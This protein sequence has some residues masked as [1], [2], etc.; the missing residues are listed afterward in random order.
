M[1]DLTDRL[2]ALSPEQRALLEARLRDKGIKAPRSTVIRPIPDRNELAHFPTSL[3]QERLWFIDQ[4]EPGNPAYN[5][6]TATRLFGP[7][8]PDLM[9]RAVNT[10]IARHEI[11][12]TT[13]QV[14]D[15]RPVQVVAPTLEIDLP[16]IDLTHVPP[17]ERE[18]A[19]QNAAVDAAS[20]RF[21]LER[22]PL[23]R[24]VLAR[25]AP[26]DHVLMICMQHA[27]TDRWSFDIFEAEVS[28]CYVAL[29][30]GGSVERPPLALQFADFAAWQREELSGENLDRH[31][32]YWRDK[33]A[34]AP[35]VL[36]IPADRPRPPVQTFNGAREYTVYPESVLEAL[37]EVTRRAGATMFMTVLAALDVLCWRY[38]GQR[39]LIIGSAI[40]DRNRPETADVIGY[41][42]NMLLLRGTIDPS[43]S[44][45]QLLAQVRETALGAYAHQD[46]PFAT[47]VSELN[48]RQDPSR[49][50]L[51]QISFIY[52]DFPVLATPE[53]A[54]FSATSLD[55]DNG[56]SRF[57]MTLACTE[58]PGTGIH[59]YIEY[60][61]DIYGKPK[62]ERMLRHLG[63]IL[64]AVAAEPDRP[65]G[66]IDILSGEERR[67]LVT[68]F[69]DTAKAYGDECLHDL[70]SRAAAGRPAEPAILFDGEA[71]SYGRLEEGASRIAGKLVACG[72]GRGSLV[73]VCVERSPEQA[74]A[75][76]G[77]L[78][79][80]AAY[81]PLDPSLP[82]GRIRRILDQTRPDLVLV[83]R[84]L[85]PVLP[86][87]GA[88]VLQV[89]DALEEQA[90]G[91]GDGL[92]SG[93]S[94]GDLAYVMFT[95][96]STGIPKGVMISHRAILNR[97]HWSQERYP[98][99]PGDRV[100]HSA[101]FGFD[102]AAWELFGPLIAGATA[103]IPRE[104][105]HKDAGALA[106]L[107]AEHGVRVAHFVP[108]MLRAF[109]EDPGVESCTALQTILC[110]GEAMDRD[111]HDRLFQ[112]FPGSTLAHFYGPTEAAISCLAHDCEPGAAGG[113]VPL[114]RPVS[115]MRIYLLDDSLQ[116]V[117]AGVPGQITIGGAGLARGYLG[118]PE[119]TADRFVPDSISGAAGERL[120]RTGDLAK[121]RE[122]GSLEFM[123]R[124]DHQIKIRGYRIE[125]G[126]IEVVLERLPGVQG[127]VAV[128]RG[129]GTERRLVAYVAGADGAPPE[130]E[131]R[132]ELRRTLPEYMVPAAIVVLPELPLG[133][134]GKVD[135]AALPEPGTPAAAGTEHV[136][137]RTET[138]EVIAGI[139]KALLRRDRV[140]V[141]DNFFDLGG[142]SLLA[143][144]VISRVRAAFDIDL[145]LRRFFE[146]STV[147]SLAGAVEEILIQRIE[148][149][150]D[151][152]AS[153]RLDNA[154][155]S[156]G[157]G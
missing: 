22:G 86:R 126:E 136:A 149:M 75:L 14:V 68:G 16:V 31:L 27:I 34:G 119:L 12:R 45:N 85:M 25:L 127:A 11:L 107:V 125:P 152:E 103:V 38:S 46:V 155:G 55:V 67:G 92:P 62:V 41:F 47:L 69:N 40:A 72:T 129:A 133:A 99:H 58:L 88:P 141:E 108:S 93:S 18:R 120:Y 33:L 61:T 84:R 147:A 48:P 153:R 110:G 111:V 106:R 17:S 65:L 51:I 116:P 9:R 105:E 138:E 57:D 56:A 137:P 142:D 115:N 5:I 24:V 122:D 134:N 124:S 35:T 8:D 96:G 70:V 6:H 42:L 28:Q 76:L 20:I 21:D 4:M 10:S 26:E 37:K 1:A 98:I 135:R 148:S 89:E 3:D 140:G 150:S 13:F 146:G 132:A 118:R 109:L 143:T 112:R 157:A 145:P 128:A 117:P 77:V 2:A 79:A 66:T 64:E 121:F 7:I 71:T 154:R 83:S 156:F 101:S 30:D 23:I 100:L 53:Y 19:A 113:P 82:A 43:M 94:P 44:F 39:D 49:N 74:M 87:T 139:W 81:V 80:G 97:I 123:G 29:R 15:G 95:S 59:S 50:P 32:S 131:M 36:E 102:I 151:E 60:N 91:R 90:G 78:K 144:Q 130:D 104:G 114:G 54:G 63:R 52:L 73:P